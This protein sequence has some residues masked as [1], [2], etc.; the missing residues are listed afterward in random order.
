ME[1]KER[2]TIRQKNKVKQRIRYTAVFLIGIAVGLFLGLLSGKTLVFVGESD[3]DRSNDYSLDKT[4]I[5]E[6]VSRGLTEE[7]TPE[8]DKK[9]QSG[10]DDKSE[11]DE[12]PQS[13]K[14]DKTEE[15]SSETDKKLTDDR[16]DEDGEELPKNDTKTKSQKGR[17][18]VIDAGHQRSGNSQKEPI[19]PG[20]SEMKAKVTYGATGS[21]TGNP[22]Y[23]V[24][25]DVAILLEKELIARGYDVI[26]VRRGHD[27][28]I[29]NSERA[30][31]ANDANA[32]AFIR[33][34]CNDVDDSSV[35]GALTMC[36]T[37]KN[38]YCS[39]YDE[40]RELSECVLSGLCAET[41]AKKRGVTET[42]GMSGI[43]WCSVPV[44]IV[45]M[46]FM[47]N[48]EEDRLMSDKS[49]QMKLAKGMANGIDM[50]FK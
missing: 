13:G 7:E 21:V 15:K 14:D 9:S 37:P 11:D 44:T 26:M 30:K 12:K 48:P 27:V 32:D 6:D 22:E 46:G 5:E 43:N 24:T 33:I 19:G 20:A 36:Q 31:V 50:Y 41:G 10:A 2:R 29:S 3:G 17:T 49:Y 40:S 47:S 28:D 45:E 8:K 1:L 39:R 23:A 38:K 25:L 4:V 42:D 35:K 34:H 16:E 18:V